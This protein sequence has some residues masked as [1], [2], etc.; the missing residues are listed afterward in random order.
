MCF[1]N[2]PFRFRP[3]SCFPAEKHTWVVFYFLQHFQALLQMDSRTKGEQETDVRERASYPFRAYISSVCILSS[4]GVNVY[5]TPHLPPTEGCRG[6]RTEQNISLQ[7]WALFNP[8]PT[9]SNTN[10]LLPWPYPNLST[11]FPS[12]SPFLCFYSWC[13]DFN[14]E[15][16]R[17]E[18]IF[19]LNAR[20][21][22]I[23]LALCSAV[24]KVWIP[25]WHCA[26]TNIQQQ[27]LSWTVGAAAMFS[28]RTGWYCTDRLILHRHARLCTLSFFFFLIAEVFILTFYSLLK[29]ETA[30]FVKVIRAGQQK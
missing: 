16:M 14:N 23:T 7:L 3:K 8:P 12:F 5:N 22:F 1:L 20:L 4:D 18:N 24:V 29:V 21:H 15:R 11:A 25:L 9:T 27:S 19:Q 2:S 13:L 10:T 6:Y 30:Q 28:S 26:L 17:T